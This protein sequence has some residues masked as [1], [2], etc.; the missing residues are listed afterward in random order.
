MAPPG[1]R[2]P[3]SSTK[4]SSSEAG[5]TAVE[6]GL[7]FMTGMR[8]SACGGSTIADATKDKGVLVHRPPRQ[9]EPGP[10]HDGPADRVA[11][12]WK[13]GRRLV[14]EPKLLMSR[15][16]LW[17]SGTRRALLKG[18][19][20]APVVPARR[21]RTWYRRTVNIEIVTTV[22][23]A[24]A[25]LIGVWRMLAKTEDSLVARINRVEAGLIQRIDRLEDRLDQ[26]ID[27]LDQR[28]D[29]VLLADRHPPAA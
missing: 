14:A 3:P 8:R 2:S 18:E 7:L 6:R 20:Q 17:R 1:P 22:L 16:R 23:S 13:R 15:C 26:R 25:I 24:A 28:I 12:L 10:Q 27:R 19:L 21:R 5:L 9:D 11:L 4:S 29:A